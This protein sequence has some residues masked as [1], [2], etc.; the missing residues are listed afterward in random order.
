MADKFHHRARTQNIE[1]PDMVVHEQ[2]GDETLWLIPETSL[3]ETLERALR[4]LH[5][6]VEGQMANPQP[7]EPLFRH[8]SHQRLY[9]L[10]DMLLDIA[11]SE[12]GPLDREDLAELVSEVLLRRE[13]S[14]VG[15]G[16]K[17]PTVQE[18]VKRPQ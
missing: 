14:G 10:R 13:K 3:E 18:S 6:A 5:R 4:R 16:M 12:V 7:A 1:F 15:M 9:D 8:L 11:R 17:P 2:E